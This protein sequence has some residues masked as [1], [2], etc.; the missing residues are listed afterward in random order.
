MD[1]I[2]FVSNEAN[3]K[4]EIYIVLFR[5]IPYVELTFKTAK[6]PYFF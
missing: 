6:L 4:H 5:L 3:N 2:V 1:N